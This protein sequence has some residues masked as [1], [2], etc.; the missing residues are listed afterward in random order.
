MQRP[1]LEEQGAGQRVALEVGAPSL[2]G[3]RVGISSS[4]W[5]AV[6]WPAWEAILCLF[7]AEL[8]LGPKT[9]FAH[10]AMLYN[11]G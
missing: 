2:H 10:P 5:R 11:F 8:D 1:L 7:R 6:K 3:E 4:T 9:K